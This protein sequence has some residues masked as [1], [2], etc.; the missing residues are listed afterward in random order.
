MN[1]SPHVSEDYDDLQETWLPWQDK[2]MCPNVCLF[3]AQNGD[4]PLHYGS[5]TQ[6]GYWMLVSVVACCRLKNNITVQVVFCERCI[7]NIRVA[8]MYA[9]S[10][11]FYMAPTKCWTWYT[12]LRV[13]RVMPNFWERVSGIVGSGRFWMT[14]QVDSGTF[15]CRNN[16]HI[17]V[18][19][20]NKSTKPNKSWANHTKIDPILP[21]LALN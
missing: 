20:Q 10:G 13:K 12:H 5:G 8:N 7:I 19:R 14:V 17:N 11:M 9:A 21:I 4:Q 2:L 6:A 18:F 3:Q 16:F 1:T 15:F